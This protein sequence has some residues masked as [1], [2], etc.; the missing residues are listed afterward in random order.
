MD[1]MLMTRSGIPTNASLAAWPAV[2]CYRVYVTP[3]MAREWL[4]AG[5][6]DNR[7]VRRTVVRRYVEM[8]KSGEW[9]TTHQGIAFS[10]RRLI[11]GQHRLL[12]IE[13]A[14]V[15]QW[16]FVFVE[17]ADD[18]FGVI[19][20][21]SQRTIRDDMQDH[22]RVVDAVSWLARV[23]TNESR[24]PPMARVREIAEMF[25]PTLH[26][27]V[28]ATGAKGRAR[29][30]APAR[31]AASI[32]IALAKDEA[33]RQFLIDQWVAWS[34]L[35]FEAMTPW[36]QAGVRRM[37]NT[38]FAGSVVSKERAAI[39]WQAFNPHP[40]Q[41]TRSEKRE[42]PRIIIRNLDT[43]IAEIREGIAAVMEKA[44]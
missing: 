44:A 7:Y 9:R 5:N 31:A 30:S 36:V 21:G 20:R 13:E 32:R 29:T 11:D 3:A 28:E 8:M 19:D 26:S 1:T 43:E 34:T 40:P 18:V 38:G 35:N 41:R 37:E 17:Q 14:G 42:Q 23:E 12:A 33:E 4:D 27:M 16:M 15:A 6:I 39:A 10:N 22:S 24:M 25:G 2:Q